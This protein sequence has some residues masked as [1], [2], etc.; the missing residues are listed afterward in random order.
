[1]TQSD[2]S[3]TTH[4]L[5]IDIDWSPDW[6]LDELAS[7][8]IKTGIKATWFVT[9][10][11]QAVERLRQRADLF[12][13][14]I[15]PNCLQGSTH[16]V[17][18]EEVLDNIKAVV[19]EAVSMRTHGLYQTTRFLILAAREYGIR[20]DS[21]LYQP[22]ACYAVPYELRF[23]STTLLRAP[24]CWADDLTLHD[25]KGNWSPDQM[26]T[27]EGGVKIYAFH[28]FHVMLNTRKYALYETLKRDRPLPEWSRK[29]IDA[30]VTA[31]IGP[32]TAFQEL[33]AML[34][35]IDSFRMR[36]L[37]HRQTAIQ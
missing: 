3:I 13:L 31:G 9:H 33:L 6:M 11:C 8:L 17:S 7:R 1:M 10:A 21:S 16:G 26:E 22:D 35:N 12:E 28:P 30:H 34:S 18:E 2:G 23:G 24:F 20:V 15:H 36:D 5:T 29:Y 32:Q 4:I 37:I 27:G 14:G 25:P 19:P